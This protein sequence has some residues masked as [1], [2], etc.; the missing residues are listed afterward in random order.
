MD[1]AKSKRAVAV[2]LTDD[3]VPSVPKPRAVRAAVSVGLALPV[4]PALTFGTG[5]HGMRA[6]PT[7]RPDA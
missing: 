2:G 5:G 6:V 7:M 4:T 3:P 1:G